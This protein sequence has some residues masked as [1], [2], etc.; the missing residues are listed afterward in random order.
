MKNEIYTIK[1]FFQKE[2]AFFI[3]IN[4]K[5]TKR[6]LIPAN[7]KIAIPVYFNLGEKGDKKPET[8]VKMYNMIIVL[9]LGF[10]ISY[11]L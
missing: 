7:I 10:F 3:S 8:K 6:N 4:W 2:C 9:I 1:I 5:T 11:D